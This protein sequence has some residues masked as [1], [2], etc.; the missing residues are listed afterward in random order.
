VLSTASGHRT[1]FA[2]ER[3]VLNQCNAVMGIDVREER[4]GNPQ[5]GESGS[6]VESQT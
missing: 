3:A 2:R 4:T 5:L 6:A 1:R